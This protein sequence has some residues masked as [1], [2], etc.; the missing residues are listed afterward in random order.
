MRW[1]KRCTPLHNDVSVGEPR[2]RAIKQAS[3]IRAY[4]VLR[5]IWGTESG[6]S[7]DVLPGLVQ[8]PIA[9]PLRV[10]KVAVPHQRRLHSYKS[11]FHD[12]CCIA[13]PAP[14]RN[15]SLLT[16]VKLLL[17]SMPPAAI[18]TGITALSDC[19][20]NV[21]GNEHQLYARARVQ[22]SFLIA[23]SLSTAADKYTTTTSVGFSSNLW[24]SHVVALWWTY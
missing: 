15:G 6:M 16:C 7:S 8:S 22:S 21:I 18:G 14:T 10:A 2:L 23:T 12:S 5:N 17:L 13:L 9:R 24:S 19:S 11:S 3:I 1:T 20:C 4:P